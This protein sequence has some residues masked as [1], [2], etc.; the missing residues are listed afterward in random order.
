MDD[1]NQ[2]NLT[3]NGNAQLPTNGGV[4]QSN[5]G[6]QPV[7]NNL[8]SQN[9]NSADVSNPAPT[10]P[11]QSDSLLTDKTHPEDLEERWISWKCLQC[12]FVYEGVVPKNV[13]PRCGNSDPD[14]FD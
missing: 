8:G 3:N 5:V 12:N 9:V 7:N 14:K 4:G 13:C 11:S 2:V 1:S 6:G 10:N